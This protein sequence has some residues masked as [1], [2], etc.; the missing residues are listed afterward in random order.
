M[1]IKS[2]EKSLQASNFLPPLEDAVMCDNTQLVEKLLK[3]GATVNVSNLKNDTL[4]HLAVQRR[5]KH[6]VQLFSRYQL[7]LT[8]KTGQTPLFWALLSC[9]TTLVEMLLK[10]GAHVNITDRTGATPLGI[11]VKCSKDLIELLLRYGADVNGRNHRGE[12]AL[13]D[14]VNM[15][16]THKV[17]VL[18]CA[19]VNVNIGDRNGNTALHVAI[20]RSYRRGFDNVNIGDRNGNTALHVAI[21]RSYRRGFEETMISTLLIANA[22]VN[23]VDKFGDTPLHNAVSIGF[24]GAVQLILQDD[25][26]FRHSSPTSLNPSIKNPSKTKKYKTCVNMESQN[27]DTPLSYAIKSENACLE[28]KKMTAI[29]IKKAEMRPYR[30]CD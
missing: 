30:N 14:A 29:A 5:N 25:S 9:D 15:D 13:F 10:Q 18:L 3:A 23:I 21:N 11:S 6:L 28:R 27:G 16:N 8:N 4:L 19:G 26:N 12:T 24:R 17:K 7:N 20:N 1:L 22:D 2:I